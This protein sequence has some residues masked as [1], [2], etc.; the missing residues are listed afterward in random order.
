MRSET[1][2][3]IG[4]LKT[5]SLWLDN[6]EKMG[7]NILQLLPMN[8]MPPGGSCPYTALSAFALDPIYISVGDIPELREDSF[9]D[10]R[11]GLGSSSFRTNIKK[12]HDSE[13]VDYEGVRKIKFAALSNIFCRFYTEHIEKKSAE[14]GIFGEYC[15]A[16]E[17]WLDDYSVFRRLKD[18][19]GW[20][21][22]LDWEKE[23]AGHDKDALDKF[24]GKEKTQ[25]MFFKYL[26]W[27]LERQWTEV[28]KKAAGNRIK[29][30]G[31][32]PF[33]VNQE[34]ADV[35]AQRNEF[36]LTKEAG[37]PP[38]ALSADGQKWGL[39][40]YNWSAARGN[41][42]KWWRTKVKKASDFYD[43]FRIDHM[44]GFFRTWTIPHDKTQKADFDIHDPA[45][46]RQRGKDFIEAVYGAS[47]MLPVA[48]DLGVI[49]P[50]VGEVL[51][52]LKVPGY[53]IIKWEKKNGKYIPPE[54]Y[55]S[56][57]LATT[58]THD[59]ET[60]AEWWD[61]VDA[62]EKTDMWAMITGKD[63]IKEKDLPVYA[64]AKTP[65]IARLLRAASKLVIFPWQDLTGSRVRIN[66][67]GTVGPDNWTYRFRPTA[68]K[69][70]S[71]YKPFVETM[72]KLIRENR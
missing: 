15:A 39:P 71:D 5:M 27:T 42:F 4:D 52:E 30:F 1:D 2:W 45:E 14:A 16:N 21:S 63:D 34:S 31:D 26:Q 13:K 64:V 6:L 10:I 35:W 40:V 50:Y 72:Q 55:P 49:P 41:N 48:E 36:D 54:K 60:T 47:P 3:G 37:A 20:I 29:L 61:T 7:M 22:W 12:L 9:A 69:F 57:S 18:I 17:Y 56:V 24:R 70:C 51:K 25:I 59:M 65:I 44:V 67:P 28:R 23:L 46:Q 8:E 19:T 58:S 62:K 53:K 43:F 38:D 33:M 32:L 68:E 11:A 66:M